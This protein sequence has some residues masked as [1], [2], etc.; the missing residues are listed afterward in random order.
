MGSPRESQDHPVLVMKSVIFKR[1]INTVF[2][3]SDSR[4]SE[5]THSLVSWSTSE[6]TH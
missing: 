6:Y 2:Y 1:F 5:Y 3:A 4:S